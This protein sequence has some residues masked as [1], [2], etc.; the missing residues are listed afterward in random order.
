MKQ[1]LDAKP[2]ISLLTLAAFTGSALADGTIGKQTLWSDAPVVF[3]QRQ[4][5]NMRYAAGCWS[6]NVFPLGNGRLGCT[7]FGEPKNFLS[8]SAPSPLVPCAG[9]SRKR[10]PAG[11]A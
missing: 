7:V 5:E 2:L 4:V 1:I 11:D 6:K 3:N 9:C 10:A 8:S